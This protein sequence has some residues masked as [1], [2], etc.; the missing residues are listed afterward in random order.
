MHACFQIAVVAARHM[1][2]FYVAAPLTTIDFNIA[3]GKQIVIEERPEREMSHI[4]G[5][6]IA[7][8]GILFTK[9][10]TQYKN[11]VVT[12]HCCSAPCTWFSI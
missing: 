3:T 1:V 12:C 9:D 4:N 10:V 8:P 5:V 6:R 11:E 2:P 7:A